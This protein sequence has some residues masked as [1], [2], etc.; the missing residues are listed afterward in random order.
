MKEQIQI[1][2]KYIFVLVTIFI[3]IVI[4]AFLFFRKNYLSH[5]KEIME[6]ISKEIK[7]EISDLKNENRGSYY[8]K[9]KNYKIH[10]LPIAFEIEKYNIQV[11]DSV[12]KKANSNIM[13]FYKN[14][15]GTFKKCCDYKIGM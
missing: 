12:S 3:L 10:S 1:S 11:G 2:S 7:G 13:T 8:I 15:N 9:I 14:N 4:T 5:K 6:L